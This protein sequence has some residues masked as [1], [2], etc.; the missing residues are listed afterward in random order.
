MTEPLAQVDVE[1][2]I[3]RLS[4]MA[5]KGA[6]RLTSGKVPLRDRLLCKIAVDPSGCWLWTASVDL[7]GYGRI[8][9]HGRTRVAH[10]TLYEELRGPVPEGLTLDHLCRVRRCVNP[11]H[12]EPVTHAE[13]VRR[14]EAGAHNKRKTHCKHGH[15]FTT[16]TTRIRLVDGG[17]ECLVCEKARRP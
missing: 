12:L 15:E 4:A 16:E 11:D 3:L 10:R 1:A 2:E 8:N 14:G 5:E 6:L 13:N 17:R 9:A 7:H